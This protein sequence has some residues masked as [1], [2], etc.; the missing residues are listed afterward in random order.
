VATD[1]VQSGSGASQFI[2]STPGGSQETLPPSNLFDPRRIEPHGLTGILRAGVSFDAVPAAGRVDPVISFYF[3]Q[4]LL[5]RPYTV[6]WSGKLYAPVDGVYVFGTEQLSSSRLS[7]DGT[8]IINNGAINN[9]MESSQT[10]KAG[11]HD[12]KL[13]YTDGDQSSHMYLYWVP[14]GRGRSKIPAAFLFPQ[15]GQYP[16]NPESG[17][18]PTLD[19]SDGTVLPSDRV[20]YWPPRSAQPVPNPEVQ[21]P[22]NQPPPPQPE[23]PP[24]KGEILKPIFLIGDTSTAL[25]PRPRAAVTDTV[26]NI[27]IYT[28]IDSKIHKYDPTGHETMSWDVANGANKKLAEGSGVIVQADHVFVLDAETSDLIGFSLDGKPSGNIHLCQCFFPRGITLASDGNFWIANTG[29]GKLEKVSPGGQVVSEFGE[30]GS[31]P[32]QFTEPASVWESPDG[33]LF[34][35]D[36]GNKQVQTFNS[37]LQPLAQWPIGQSIARDGNRLVGDSAG[38]VLVTQY[39]DKAVV[40]YDKDGKELNRWTFLRNGAA[41]VP[42]GIASLGN[43]K[44]LVLYPNEG[45]AAAFATK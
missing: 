2:W 1:T 30:P 36:I 27:Y 22:I 31:Q 6:E 24:A 21:Q 13:L 35:A 34:V 42:A 9:M 40:M 14:P 45:I 25:L 18:L 43:D 26:G 29:G 28:E 37:D 44:F 33:R 16:D 10:L 23:Q 5:P 15:M 20:V 3:H 38:N 8:E 41:L 39:D 11:W 7:L 32:G 17:S 19:Q 12:I 4:T